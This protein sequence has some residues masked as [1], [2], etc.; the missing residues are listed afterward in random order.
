[1]WPASMAGRQGNWRKGGMG[2]ICHW[3]RRLIREGVAVEDRLDLKACGLV[4]AGSGTGA[5]AKQTATAIQFV[6]LDSKQMHGD[7]S[8]VLVNASVVLGRREGDY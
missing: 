6:H 7:A 4:G 2:L 1:M 3:F 8:V 5:G